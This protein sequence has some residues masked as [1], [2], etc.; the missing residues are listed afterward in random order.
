M[1]RYM[2]DDDGWHEYGE[3]SWADEADIVDLTSAFIATDSCCRLTP[4]EIYERSSCPHDIADSEP[5]LDD[6]QHTRRKYL[7]THLMILIALHGWKNYHV[8]CLSLN[9]LRRECTSPRSHTLPSQKNCNNLFAQRRL[10]VPTK[11]WRGS[12][13]MWRLWFPTLF[14]RL[15]CLFHPIEVCIQVPKLG[16]LMILCTQYLLRKDWNI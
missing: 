6:D 12:M 2:V 11:D 8:V 15:N 5:K 16:Y 14:L 10:M 4:V 9:H 13:I 7:D 3:L 1:L